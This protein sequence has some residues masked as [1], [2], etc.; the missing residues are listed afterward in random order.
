[1]TN[2]I[3]VCIDCL[4]F[5][6]FRQAVDEGRF[7]PGAIE[8]QG[9]LVERCYT[10]AP[11]T[12]P[13]THSLLTGLLP[14]R[15]GAW[16]E[17]AYRYRVSQ[18]WPAPLRPG[19]PT[20]FSLL[21]PLGY[22]TAGISTIFWAL[23]QGC[24]YP[25]CDHLVRS[26]GQEVFYQNTPADW[27][28]DTFQ[29]LFRAGLGGGPFAAYLH[30]IDLHRPLDVPTG[31]AHAAE[32]VL[33]LAGI[34]DWDPRPWADRP[35]TLDLFRINRLR[36][37]DGVLA[38]VGTALERL[39]DFLEAEGVADDTVVVVVAD[40]GE[41]FWDHHAFQREH[42]SC[43]RK[44][45]EPWL[46]GTGHGHT[47]FEELIRVPLLFLDPAGL[48]PRSAAARLT[49]TVDLLPTLLEMAGAEVPPGLDGVSLLHGERDW[50]AAEGILYGHERKAVVTRRLKCIYAPGDGHVG[51]FDLLA[52]P[53]EQTALAAAPEPGLLEIA[54]DLYRRGLASARTAAWA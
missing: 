15:H 51:F 27:V 34:D 19:T 3:V 23:N 49:S 7:L 25:G 31:L 32:P 11:W 20:L 4:R 54:E 35:D 33:P 21:K 26:P 39:L 22:R 30:L 42:Y 53:G 1:M 44:S 9:V 28:V 41:E 36:L 29:A 16:H 38:Y 48:V 12:Y 10:A 46:L 47:L 40:H 17:G 45:Q 14:H 13:A 43:G 24:E 37:Y 52:D 5:D 50:L 6:R 2:F 8:R 18:P